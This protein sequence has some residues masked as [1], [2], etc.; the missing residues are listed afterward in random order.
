MDKDCYNTN[1][2]KSFNELLIFN[3]PRDGVV[4]ILVVEDSIRAQL[5]TNSS[6]RCLQLLDRFVDAYQEL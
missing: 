3:S 2:V 6:A 5:A 4:L 1:L